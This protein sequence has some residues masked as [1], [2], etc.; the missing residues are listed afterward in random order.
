APDRVSPRAEST[1]SGDLGASSADFGAPSADLGAF[2][3][4]SSAPRAATPAQAVSTIATAPHPDPGRLNTAFSPNE[5]TRDLPE[6]RSTDLRRRSN[7]AIPRAG[8]TRN[9]AR[10]ADSPPR[11]GPSTRPP[12][13][14]G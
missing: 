10:P 8:T 9:C 12:A 1:S 11:P 13:D 6:R 5:V 3:G 14:E 7:R 4:E 2:L